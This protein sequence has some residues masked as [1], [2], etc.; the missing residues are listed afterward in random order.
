MQ[1]I[2]CTGRESARDKHLATSNSC[3]WLSIP[4]LT[5]AAVQHCVAAPSCPSATLLPDVCVTHLSDPVHALSSHLCVRASTHPHIHTSQCPFPS[6]LASPAPNP[7]SPPPILRGP[8]LPPP[9][10][11][12]PT[13][14]PGACLATLHCQSAPHDACGSRIAVY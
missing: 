10:A 7:R 6:P 12:L 2:V 14:L 11:T 4:D 3:I 5:P 13:T 9:A 1:Y 8:P